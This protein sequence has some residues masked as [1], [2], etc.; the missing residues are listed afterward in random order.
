MFEM[1]EAFLGHGQADQA[2]SKLGHEVDGFG[3]DFFGGEGKVAFVLAVFVVDDDD[4]AAGA[5]FLNRVGDVGKW[6]L[7]TH[8]EAIVATARN[9]LDIWLNFF[10]AGSGKILAL[11]GLDGFDWPV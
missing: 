2:A 7:G 4:H 1:L 11:L 10:S 3:R 9:S 6:V 5:D 8:A